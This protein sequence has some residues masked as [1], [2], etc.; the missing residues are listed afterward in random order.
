MG[1][2]LVAYIDEERIVDVQGDETNPISRGRLCGRGSMFPRRLYRADRMCTP[3]ARARTTED[4][5]ECDGW[6]QALD[7]LADRL[8][9]IRD[10]YGPEALLIG[11]DPGAGL[12]FLYAGMRF[13]A[14]WGTPHVFDPF[15]Q[16]V[17]ALPQGIVASP[18]GP[19]S[20]WVHARCLFVVGADP[21]AT[22]PVAANWILEA[23][24]RGAKLV[25]ADTRFTATMSKADVALRIRPESASALGMALMQSLLDRD[26]HSSDAVEN[27]FVN[28]DAWKASFEQMS[29]HDT[30]AKIGLSP[31]E[32][33]NVA[34][35]LAAR[36]PVQ[37]ITGRSLSPLPGYGI[38][39]T[40]ATA[41]GWTGKRGGGWYPVDSGRPPVNAAAGIEELEGESTFSSCADP[42]FFLN[43]LLGEGPMD[44]A[45]RVKAVIY[46]EDCFDDSFHA[47]AQNSKTLELAACFG[48]FLSQE[49]NRPHFIF[50]ASLWAERDGLVF[51][52][53]RGIRWAKRIATPRHDT[54]SGLDFWIGLASRFG[55]EAHFPWVAEDGTADHHAFAQWLLQQNPLTKACIPA[56]WDDPG[57]G[58]RIIYWPT[59]PSSLGKI[60]PAHAWVSVEASH[61]DDPEAE[62][63]PLHL[64]S[65]HVGS[66]CT[67]LAN[68]WPWSGERGRSALLQ[69]N[70]DIATALGI[71]SGDTVIALAAGQST[72]ARAW[73]S[74]AVPRSVVYSTHMRGAKRVLVH[75]KGQTSQE[76]LHALRG[77]LP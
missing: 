52:N 9:R 21:A 33:T 13:A 26:L 69:I 4:F 12:D 59:E 71:E 61:E 55:W 29:L 16:R 5:Q 49:R 75:R 72:E 73:V 8:K 35:L 47:A 57:D 54:R 41:M 19:C 40:M 63:Y 46:S 7:L 11:C 18:D 30:A 25:V 76:A 1:C 50:P 67:D 31:E 58:A 44:K 45:S 22:H 28:A 36:G 14:L 53:D 37:L 38:W 17:N 3:M 56:L 60:E 2:G 15:V 23:Q 66:G 34:L 68:L 48:S 39:Q 42:Q 77:M 6:D 20:D 27:H 70:P 43:Q 65:P 10:Q 62:S 32:I 64:E 24:D 74:R 51:T